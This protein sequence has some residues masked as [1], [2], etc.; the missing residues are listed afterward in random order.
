MKGISIL[1]FSI[2][3]LEQKIQD[4]KKTSYQP[5]LGIVFASIKHDFVALQKV[6]RDHDIDILGASS[7]GE[8]VGEE[9]AEKGIAVLFLDIKRTTYD[10]Y[11]A[12][13]NYLNSYERGR[14][15]GQHSKKHFENAAFITVFSVTVSAEEM[16]AGIHS[17]VGE[18][19]PIFGGMASDDF[20]MNA[21]SVFTNSELSSGGLCTLILDHDKIDIHGLALS[22]WEP[23]GLVNTITKATDNMI[24]EINGK[25][26]LDEFI[27][28]CGD[29]QDGNAIDDIASISS[30]QYPLQILRE[31]TAVMRALLYAD[32][33]TKTMTMAG[34]IK[35]GD[36][37][38]FS[39][40]PG[41]EILDET[42]EGFKKYKAT[43]EHEADAVVVFSC[44]ARH[45]SLGPMIEDEIE[46]LHE[47][48]DKKPMIGF[49]SYGEVGQDDRKKAHYYNETCAIAIMKEK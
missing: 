31:D 1:A 17:V 11:F 40:A 30:A 49:F 6:F 24:Y 25:P 3:E 28:F 43:L 18:K 14:S 45:M 34:P 39:I 9:L 47:I 42:L 44:K 35:E 19:V 26:A 48:W 36:R 38:Q 46:G 21:T 37:F 10:I 2:L 7:S 8:F 20:T 12:E 22:G 13:T 16:I 33:E 41:F 5:T 4:L 15:I 29:Y 27:K 23:L 32:K